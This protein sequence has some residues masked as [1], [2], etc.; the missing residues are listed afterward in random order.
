MTDTMASLIASHQLFEAMSLEATK[1]IAGCCHNVAFG[2]D[3][4]LVAEGEEATTF[5]IIRRGHVA[6]EVHRPGKGP[7]TIETVGPGGVVGWSWLFPPYRWHLD[8]R[9]LE[10]VGAIAIDGQCL[11][12]K[13]E[14]DPQFGYLLIKRFASVM[15]EHLM[16]TQLRLLDVYGDVDAR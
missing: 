14:N 5:Y 16:A 12:T 2:M 10:P 7:L 1:L 3:D 8:A 15:L 4:V 11:R 6:L 13:A 9:A